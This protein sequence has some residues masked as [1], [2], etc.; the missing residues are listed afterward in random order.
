MPKGFSSTKSAN[1]G[2]GAWLGFAVA[3]V[4]RGPCGGVS[5]GSIVSG[6]PRS[7]IL[8]RPGAKFWGVFEG[9]LARIRF[10][11]G[12]ALSVLQVGKPY[13]VGRENWPEGVEYNYRSGCHELRMFF[14]ESSKEEVRAIRHG[15]CEFGL[16]VEGPVIFFLY[17]FGSAVRWSDAPYS[18]HLVPG[19]ERTL[20]EEE[21]PET[22]AVLQVVLVEAGSGRVLVLRAVSFSPAFTLAL[23]DAIRRQASSPWP[24]DAAYKAELAGAYGRYPGSAVLMRVAVAR[25]RGGE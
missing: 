6:Q 25:T 14:A 15:E 11:E 19:S 21:G 4:K 10:Q 7:L 5:R 12:N 18:W 22:R 9:R 13:I 23:H 3:P 16:V 1:A 2:G 17:R 20:P 8:R 24:G